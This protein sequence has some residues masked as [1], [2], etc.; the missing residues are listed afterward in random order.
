ML[1]NKLVVWGGLT[2]HESHRHI[3]R[4]FWDAARKM[5]WSSQLVDDQEQNRALLTPGTLVITADIYGVNIG[6]AMPGVQYVIHN[7]DGSHVLCQSAEPENLLR[8]QVW[9]NDAFGTQWG[10]FRA[11][12]HD[13]RILF[14]PWGTD[15]FAE[16]FMDPVFNPYSNEVTFVGAIWADQYQG[17]ELGNVKMIE[18]LQLLCAD[19]SL[20]FVHR[21]GIS[22]KENMASVR[23]AR[24]APAF[25]G[26]WQVDHNY[27]PCRVFKNISYGVLGFTNVPALKE[28]LHLPDM[29][30]NEMFE[31]AL[32]LKRTKYLGIVR[33]QQRKISRYTY[34]ESL[35]AIERALDLGRI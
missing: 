6:E 17:T 29:S 4:H 21:T 33:Q 27:L 23:S 8:L 19:N 3:H 9:T 7:F 28:L 31:W 24:L 22:D 12:D 26:G 2:G 30:H 10:D 20:K 18:D 5:G 1:N 13:S 34:R 14:Q 15:L 16:E 35:I 25:A 32:K 11:Y